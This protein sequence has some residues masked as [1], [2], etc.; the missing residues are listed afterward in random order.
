ME[1]FTVYL[2]AETTSGDQINADIVSYSAIL[3]RDKD[4]KIGEIEWQN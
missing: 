2:D 1:K 4:N 3:V